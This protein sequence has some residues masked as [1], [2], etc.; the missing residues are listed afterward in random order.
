MATPHPLVVRMQDGTE[1]TFNSLTPEL[2]A[3]L[4]SPGA[5]L[6][7]PLSGQ[8]IQTTKLPG[9]GWLATTADGFQLP[10][11]VI[12]GQGFA[13][14]QEEALA[15]L[16]QNV[17][18]SLITKWQQTGTPETVQPVQANSA[19][20]AGTPGTLEYALSTWDRLKAKANLTSQ[21]RG[22]KSWALVHIGRAKDAGLVTGDNKGSSGS[23][24]GVFTLTD[25]GKGSR[26]IFVGDI[27]RIN[28]GKPPKYDYG[29]NVPSLI[30]SR[31]EQWQQTGTPETVQPVQTN[32]APPAGH[33]LVVRMQD[34]TEQTFNSLT[35]ELDA[36]LGSPGAQLI[37]PLSGQPIQTTKL[38]GG[39]WLATTADGFQL[40]LNVIQGRGFAEGQEEALANLG[41]NVGHPLVVR[42]QDG[43]EQTFNSLT[44]ELD[45]A[46]GSPGAQLIDPLS[47]QPIQTTKLPGGG[48][49]ATTADGFQLPL[50]VIQGRGFAEGQEE[51]LANLGQNVGH[52]LVVRMQDGT[53]Q[54]F[55][56]LTPELDAALGS[57]GAQLID[58]LSGQPI[59]TTKLPGGGWLATTA[60]GFQLPLNVIQGRGFAEGQEEALANLGGGGPL[61][62]DFGTFMEPWTKE[63]SYDPGKASETDAFKFQFD[64]GMKALNRASSAGGR[65]DS[66]RAR[67]DAMRFGQ[68]LAATYDDRYYNRARGEFDLARNIFR[69]NQSD[70]FNKLASVSGLAQVA[71]AE[72]GTAG[73]DYAGNTGNIL[74]NT[75]GQQA[76]YAA[77]GANAR[78]SGYVG[79]ANAVNQGISN[80]NQA[81]QDYW[82]YRDI[83]G[84]RN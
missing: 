43:T 36:A 61:P 55:N 19:P 24:K 32:S 30:T 1:Q 7:D 66:G 79:S 12:Q 59:Q 48:W 39:G 53:E 49:L 3:A 57:P 72:L 47:G 58:P 18:P 52:P 20:P 75:A 70:R 27:N 14:G 23:N 38:P 26:Q 82:L 15:N 29:Q 54:T 46:L 73:R 62:D 69:T 40:P 83:Y 80:V 81:A 5:Q 10:L 56:S 34:G 63:F 68:G 13:E 76:E 21:D 44:P 67:K 78:A 71:G 2:D 11:N 6:I 60:D 42:M 4:G 37:D 41:Q 74:L 17:P 9:G 77:Q 65:I 33:P 50:N 25:L 28:Q 8:P 84:R 16:G 31:Q 22:R 64:E 45:A 51:A 35:P